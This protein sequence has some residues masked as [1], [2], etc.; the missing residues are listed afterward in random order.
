MI[1]GAWADAY[2][3][4]NP[5]SLAPLPPPFNPTKS[6]ETFQSELLFFFLLSHFLF[7]S[8]FGIFA[9]RLQSLFTSTPIPNLQS[10]VPCP[11]STCKQ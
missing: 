3:S 11:A 2:K 6:Q 1:N 9:S 4:G 8:A 5:N 7:L 10:L